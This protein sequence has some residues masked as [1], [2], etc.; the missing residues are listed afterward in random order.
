MNRVKIGAEYTGGEC[1]TFTV[2]SPLSSSVEL[3]IFYPEPRIVAMDSVENGYWTKKA[4]GIKPGCRYLYRI[5]KTEERPDPASAFQPEGV[6]G[7]SEVVDHRSFRWN[8]GRWKAPPAE[9]MIIYEIHTG[10]FTPEGTFD[11]IVPR[12]PEL[13][14]LGVTAIEL[15]PVAQFPGERN[16]G[17]D[18]VYPFAVQNSYGGPDGLKRLCDACHETGL[19]LFLDV[20]YNHLGPE[21][22][23]LSLFGPYFTGRYRTAWGDAL[24]FDGEYSDGVRNYF[25]M[26]VLHWFDNY[27][28]DG[29]RL[30]A[31]HGIY[32]HSATHILQELA[33]EVKSYSHSTGRD[34]RL[35]AE[36]DLNDSRIVKAV[37]KGGYSI[38]AQWCDDFHH[39]VHTLITGEDSGYYCDFGKME[40]LEKA[41]SSGF[42]YTGEYSRFRK[43]KHG[44]SSS[45]IPGSRLIVCTQNHDQVGNRMFGDRL[46]SIAGFEA[47]KL[48]AGTLMIAPFIPLLF[49][50]E[51]YG[52]RAPFLY[53]VSHGDRDLVEAVRRGRREEFASFG[54]EDEPPDP[55][56]PLTFMNSKPD[57]KLIC[58]AEHAAMYRYYR[59]L[60]RMR[61]GTP[62]I[63][64]LS[65]KN[66]ATEISGGGS[67]LTVRRSYRGSEIFALMNYSSKESSVTAG[68]K[69]ICY[70]I[71]IDSADTEW[72]GPGVSAPDE[73][74]KRRDIILRPYNFI[75]YSVGGGG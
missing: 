26:N 61:K 2:W 40:N 15:M 1:C 73:I 41:F 71:L 37:Q 60:I 51:E 63:R 36:S 56:D 55:Q 27:N 39:S 14:E 65:R 69:G 67:I 46:I 33:E 58:M 72:N 5:D 8:T 59:E 68:G 44:N 18:G 21:G 6:H 22:N 74:K 53:F 20:V 75:V 24:N 62:A 29:L 19:A 10:T 38:D 32:D 70:N 57:R 64:S 30:D 49:M 50:G 17:Y 13:K 35:I 16:W 66:L 4:D 31:V 9:K 28:V 43:R 23:Y 42:V 48:A 34:C 54:W 12:L 3:E 47:Q 52:E 25:V 7:P 11:A 45:E